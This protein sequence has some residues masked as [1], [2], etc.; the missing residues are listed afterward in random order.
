MEISSFQARI[1]RFMLSQPEGRCEL[2][3]LRIEFM[4]VSIHLLDFHL[5]QLVLKE[6]VEKDG[7][8]VWMTEK[9]GKAQGQLSE[10]G[11]IPHDLIVSV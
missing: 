8:G 3:R 11:P 10:D 9:G 2:R 4:P 5:S 6:L 7:T 1:L